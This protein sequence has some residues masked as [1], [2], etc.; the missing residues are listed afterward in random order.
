[1]NIE[2]HVQEKKD[3]EEWNDRAV[4]GS[5]ASALWSFDLLAK[6]IEGRHTVGVHQARLV[7]IVTMMESSSA[8]ARPI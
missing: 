3:G 2:Y 5:P 6:E 7:A 8:V 1:M 4:S